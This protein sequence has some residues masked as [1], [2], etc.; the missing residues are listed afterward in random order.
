M[1]VQVQQRSFRIQIDSLVNQHQ[2]HSNHLIRQPYNLSSSVSHSQTDASLSLNPLSSALGFLSSSSSKAFSNSQA[3]ATSTSEIHMKSMATSALGLTG[4]IAKIL[5]QLGSSSLFSA[6]IQ[7]E[8]NVSLNAAITNPVVA[9]E[10][11]VRFVDMLDCLEDPLFV[12]QLVFGSHKVSGVTG[13]YS[14]MTS[15]SSSVSHS[16]AATRQQKLGA[17]TASSISN[18]LNTQSAKIS[19]P[20]LKMRPAAP[21]SV[22]AIA[23]KHKLLAT[24]RKPTATTSSISSK[25]SSEQDEETLPK[26]NLFESQ[27]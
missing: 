5:S 14:R 9:P 17:P 6:T 23:R 4:S 1:R 16:A 18:H 2:H 21:M 22:M 19:G 20:V 26:Q 11:S 27:S 25:D 24:Q 8:S 15:F 7:P 12:L 13:F 3:L 10:Q